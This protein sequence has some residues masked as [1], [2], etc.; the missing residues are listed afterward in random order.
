MS[1]NESKETKV[2]LYVGPLAPG[3]TCLQ[4][5]RTFQELG[6]SLTSINSAPNWAMK[7][8][9]LPLSYRIIHKLI[10]SPDLTRVNRLI[11]HLVA[12]QRFD[13]LW[14]D[15]GLVIKPETLRKVKES[16]PG[17]A[18]VGYSP[19]DMAAQA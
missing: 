16:S 8:K 15:K 18:I 12:E 13:I 7:Q 14:L 5:M 9:K 11:D 10:D 4:R 17:T 1:I 2:I 6:H 3:G 19:D